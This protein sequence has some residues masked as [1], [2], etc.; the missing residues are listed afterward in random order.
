MQKQ[1]SCPVRAFSIG[2]EA[3]GYNEAFLQGSGPASRTDHTES[4]LL[5][6]SWKST[7]LVSNLRRAFADSSQIPTFLVSEL[8]KKTLPSP[9]GDGG[10]ELLAVTADIV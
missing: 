6:T 8:T 3:E 7:P 4:T 5:K 2:F 1:S 10:D 9:L